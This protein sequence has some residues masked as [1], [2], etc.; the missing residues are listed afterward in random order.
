MKEA[1]A[2]VDKKARDV[3]GGSLT[4][5]VRQLRRVA[6]EARTSGLTID[7]DFADR[8]A[9]IA[10]KADGPIRDVQK[11]IGSLASGGA[12]RME[13]L[14]TNVKLNMRLIV[15]RWIVAAKKASGR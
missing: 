4:E 3:S 7:R 11:A 8:V 9:G 14:Q 2:D 6:A 15:G 13:D 10:N 12:R 5:Y 1:L